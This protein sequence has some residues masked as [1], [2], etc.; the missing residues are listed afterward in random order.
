MWGYRDDEDEIKIGD[1]PIRLLKRIDSDELRRDKINV[2]IG[3]EYP[4][5]WDYYFEIGYRLYMFPDKKTWKQVHKTLTKSPKALEAWNKATK[6]LACSRQPFV[7][8]KGVRWEEFI[9]TD[10]VKEALG[11][12][13]SL[14]NK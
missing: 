2:I 6:V 7:Y 5:N 4:S 3:D 13:A 11:L 14:N 1:L 12:D 10:D 9:A 8:P